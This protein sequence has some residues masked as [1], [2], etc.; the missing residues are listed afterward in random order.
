MKATSS[1][2]A[3]T[4]GK[5]VAMSA[6]GLLLVLFLIM[7]LIENLLIFKS[8]E[9]FNEWSHFLTVSMVPW[10]YL[11]EFGLLAL[12]IFHI[13]SAFQLNS[14]NRAARPER[15]YG[16]GQA[17]HTSRKTLMSSNMLRTI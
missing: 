1:F 16:F 7:H 15:Y 14:L 12:F 5:K 10:I 17:Q 13:V 6:T 3:S 8:K 9:V 11:A 2:L 4:I